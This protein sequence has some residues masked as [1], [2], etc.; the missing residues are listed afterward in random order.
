MTK[1]TGQ[2]DLL[3]EAKYRHSEAKKLL[4]RA[5][6]KIDPQITA[7]I[8]GLLKRIDQA[9]KVK[10]QDALRKDIE[11]LEPLVSRHLSRF[12]KSAL[13]EYSESIGLAILFALVLR[14]FVVEAF[15]IPSESM[16]PTLMIGDH[17]FV[18]KFVYGLRIP[19]TRTDLIEFSEPDHGEVV[20][21]IFP[22]KEVRT[23]H[24][25]GEIMTFLIAARSRSAADAYPETLEEIGLGDRVDD[26]GN[27]FA[28][29]R[30]GPDSYRLASRGPDGQ[31]GT[32]DDLTDQNSAIRPGQ[33]PCLTQENL[34]DAKDYIK[35]VIGV[36]G[37]RVRLEDNVVYVNDV[38]LEQIELPTPA[39]AP[40]SRFGRPLISALERHGDSE[41]VVQYYGTSPGFPEVTVRE[42]HLFVMG[43]NR[44]NSADSRC[45]GQVPIENVKGRALFLFWSGGQSGRF[46]G[47]RW[48]RMFDL[49]E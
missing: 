18:N 23:Q 33:R 12:R 16:L 26:W 24:Q 41:Y 1:A 14:A 13:R 45:W 44:D 3:R 28:Y 39:D 5:R 42:G 48:E 37:D 20:V 35:R 38:P 43:D 40:V 9:R 31:L 4:R 46:L 15:Q 27:P 11:E 21:F 32:G 8:G 30:I 19:F 25:I 47:N 29:E 22:V 49:V 36:P 2:R 10:D 7:E 6:R 34:E 17:L